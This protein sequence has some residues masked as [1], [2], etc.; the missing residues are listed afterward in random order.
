MHMLIPLFTDSHSRR[1]FVI[2]F[3]LISY[4]PRNRRVINTVLV[5]M[6]KFCDGRFSTW[7][8]KKRFE[9]F[10]VWVVWVVWK[11]FQISQIWR[12]QTRCALILWATRARYGTFAKVATALDTSDMTVEGSSNEI[13]VGV[14]NSTHISYL[15]FIV[16]GY[17]TYNNIEFYSLTYHI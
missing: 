8:K 7:G 14:Y 5:K 13:L 17:M 11:P 6:C 3:S 16:Q 1:V 12:F 4:V 9:S 10:V 15:L 2:D